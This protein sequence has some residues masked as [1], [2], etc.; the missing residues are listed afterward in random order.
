MEEQWRE[1]LRKRFEDRQQPAPDG[2]WDSINAAMTERGLS[3]AAE[4]KPA[5]RTRTVRMWIR[6]TAAAVA[7]VAIIAGTAVYLTG[8]DDAQ[9]AVMT[10]SGAQQEQQKASA[11][12]EGSAASDNSTVSSVLSSATKI[13]HRL[14]AVAERAADAQ[15]AKT[16]EEIYAESTE[17]PV[18]TAENVSTDNKDNNVT[19]KGNTE[20]GTGKSVWERYTPT[21]SHRGNGYRHTADSRRKSSGHHAARTSDITVGLYGTGMAAIDMS[22]GN[23]DGDLMYDDAA[24]SINGDHSYTLMSEI[25]TDSHMP[26]PVPGEA[27]EKHRQP[28]KVGLSARMM[29]SDRLA[30][31]SGMFYSY[32]SSDFEQSDNRNSYKTEQRL[33][34]IG[35]PLKMTYSALKT[36]YVDVYGGLGGAVEIGVGGTSRTDRVADGKVVSSAETSLRE[37]RPQFSVTASAGVQYNASDLIGIYAEPGVSYYIDNGSGISN[38]YKDKPWNF[39]LSIGLRLTLK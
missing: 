21:D 8:G 9:M 31:E 30:V 19:A 1:S 17:N 22:T 28:V 16:A 24:S 4:K 18:L 12:S 14:T 10:V 2:L 34:Y 20:S 7:C 5:Q 25:L 26:Q 33:H 29:L 27:T 6:R 35:I 32:L 11:E 39:N 36:D 37:K 23:G 15:R 3:G 13:A 38:F